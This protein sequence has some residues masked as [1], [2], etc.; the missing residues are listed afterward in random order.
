M[1]NNVDTVFEWK[2]KK[3]YE[4]N[5][6]RIRIYWVT[7][8]TAIV[9]ATDINEHLG[10]QVANATKEIISFVTDFYN[11]AP[12]KTMLVEQY[13]TGNSSDED[14]YL[15]VLIMGSLSLRYEV[16]ISKLIKLIGREI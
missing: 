6:C 16:K 11:L 1:T 2:T 3:K 5:K 12:N 14:T 4:C 15:Q 13:L 10:L 8:E 7:W 9:I